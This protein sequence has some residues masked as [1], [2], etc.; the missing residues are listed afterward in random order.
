MDLNRRHK[1][2]GR[3]VDGL[4]KGEVQRWTASRRLTGTRL[5]R[6]IS[7]C[8]VSDCAGE[9]STLKIYL[10]TSH[11]PGSSS[12]RPSCLGRWENPMQHAPTCL[13]E[14]SYPSSLGAMAT[15]VN[16]VVL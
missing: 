10:V 5:G 4:Q 3:R 6:G 13:W 7:G 2:S 11:R 8:T 1:L 12:G 16:D 14:L 9:G 15:F